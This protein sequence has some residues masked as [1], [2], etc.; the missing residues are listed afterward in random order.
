MNGWPITW[1]FFPTLSYKEG[2]RGKSWR[3]K[4]N[5]SKGIWLIQGFTSQQLLETS[6]GLDYFSDQVCFP[7]CL[8]NSRLERK[9]RCMMCVESDVALEGETHTSLHFEEV[10]ITPKS[11]AFISRV[12]HFI[13][14]TVNEMKFRLQAQAELKAQ[15]QIELLVSRTQHTKWQSGGPRKPW[16]CLKHNLLS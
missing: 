9:A 16:N 12:C 11:Q 5:N 3:R 4:S 13:Y 2:R 15:F 8:M 7:S 10:S 6:S 1:F 14:L